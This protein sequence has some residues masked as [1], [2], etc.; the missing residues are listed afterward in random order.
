MTCENCQTTITEKYGSGR[1][2][3]AKCARGFSTKSKRDEINKKV[4]E[5]LTGKRLSPSH[6]WVNHSGLSPEAQ[7]KAA[8]SLKKNSA[9]RREQRIAAGHWDDLSFKDRKAR[10]LI[11]QHHQC[12][13]C[14][15]DEWQGKP[16]A[17]HYD[18]IDGNN[19]NN[20]R[21]NVRCIC[22]N[23]HSQTETY[24]GRNVRLKRKQREEK[25]GS[26]S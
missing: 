9:T 11:E 22:P 21:S 23:C 26:D 5:K 17:L 4:S 2:C 12:M 18:H 1:F 19:E 15:I 3:S 8:E 13:I 24:A 14:L 25:A 6:P 10:V 7:R 20:A 16:I